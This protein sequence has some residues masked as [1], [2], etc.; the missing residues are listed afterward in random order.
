MNHRYVSNIVPW[1]DFNQVHAIGINNFC[2][3]IDGVFNLSITS[4]TDAAQPNLYDLIDPR[5]LG[6]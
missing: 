6:G 3:V 5:H 2:T 1:S 4:T